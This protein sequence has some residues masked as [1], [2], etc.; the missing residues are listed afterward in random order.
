MT[1]GVTLTTS[2][3]GEL[4]NGTANDDTLTALHANDTLVGG[5]GD[6]QLQGWDLMK[7]PYRDTYL[8]YPT[9]GGA[10]TYRFD[11]GWGH[12][13]VRDLGLP[14]AQDVIEFGA[15]VR[16]Q[17]LALS[18]TPYN[19]GSP[20]DNALIVTNKVTGD[21]LTIFGAFDVQGKTAA[22]AIELIR[23][24][25]G[26][27]IN[28]EDW[29]ALVPRVRTGPSS[30]ADT[31]MG[32]I[33]GDTLYGVGDDTLIASHGT[34]LLAGGNGSDRIDA[35]ADAAA[36]V[37]SVQWV[38]SSGNDV[39][40]VGSE[41][42]IQLLA[43]APDLLVGP[44][45]ADGSVTLRD[46]SVERASGNP[47]QLFVGSRS[48][49][50]EDLAAS[51]A[52]KLVLSD[53]TTLTGQDI[54]KR[55]A[56]VT[57]VNL[58][59]GA[60]KDSLSGGQ[61]ADVLQGGGGNDSLYGYAGNDQLL[62]GL[63][64]D[65][66]VGGSGNDTMDGGAG[67]DRYVVG[68]ANDRDTIALD[69]LDSLQIL[70]MDLSLGGTQWLANLYDINQ[71]AP[72]ITMAGSTVHIR[73]SDLDS[74]DLGNVGTWDDA[75]IL[76]AQGNEL[77]RG[78]DLVALA[79]AEPGRELVGTA[80]N[81]Q[82]QGGY[83]DDTLQGLEGDDLLDGGR[84]G[85]DVLDGGA[86]NDT[87]VGVAAGQRAM[88]D[89]IGGAGNDE[90]RVDSSKGDV[91]VRVGEGSDVLRNIGGRTDVYLYDSTTPNNPVALGDVRWAV[92]GQ[93]LL[94]RSAT[95][96]EQ[97][98][99]DHY[100]ATD[101]SQPYGA[102]RSVNFLTRT[103][104]EQALTKGTAGD[105]Q[106]YALGLAAVSLSGGAGNDGLHGGAGNDTLNGGQGADTI[107][108]GAGAD[109]IVFA[110][111][112]GNDVLHADASDTLK[113]GAGLTLADMRIGKL[114]AEAAGRVTLSLAG[115]DSIALDDAG[116]WDGL[117]LV[118]ANGQSTTGAAILNAARSTGVKP[119]QGT[120]GNDTL[121]GAAGQDTLIGLAGK[122][123]LIGGWGD[124][125]LQGG[126]GADTYV[127]SRG[128][129][130]DTI[131]DNDSAWL[132]TDTLQ[133]GGAQSDQ[134]WFSRQGNNLDVSLIGTTDHVTV[135]DWFLGAANQVEKIT[136]LGD[137]KSLTV[138]K[139]N[140]LVN[141][142]SSYSAPQL[143]QTTWPASEPA[144]LTK[145]VASSWA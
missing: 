10:T 37:V 58:T 115:G 119:I 61:K 76:D 57:A 143:G 87:L 134:L 22:G 14:G 15:G 82:L 8:L 74:I 133:F 38:A 118:F 116:Q 136:A 122:D 63:G 4:L 12:D 123:T 107:W 62:G 7:V 32:Q 128:D 126:T 142:M 89:L 44:V 91:I 86:G 145:L 16:P 42:T 24:A 121:L 130:H 135:K 111:G 27:S 70:G 102:V 55:A 117:K 81:D 45:N 25:D 56:A 101:V 68:Y 5:A 99:I 18:V 114:G 9:L 73:I 65:L 75:R 23:F 3:D 108:G 104:I 95:T 31:V 79:R 140:A 13:T 77:M 141:A 85:S 90:F 113:L 6:D 131:V 28:W 64:N 125:L 94:V 53:G 48:L 112:D 29:V 100:F 36:N 33:A 49:T 59:G 1:M 40:R 17:D 129:G 39:V 54:L 47:S 137:N 83:G 138:S 120:S 88:L 132:V 21:T 127:F 34:A 78:I 124:D 50:L 103:D 30:G 96:G 11:S 51:P 110:A 84:Y 67:A 80:G 35:R 2:G 19:G 98:R 26:S 106:L 43:T 109:T 71:L 69:N 52:A 46:R 20:S 92:D 144:S 97:L 93:D 66:I 72:N 105:D 60:G 139:V 41:D